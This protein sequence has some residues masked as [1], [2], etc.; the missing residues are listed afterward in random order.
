MWGSGI[1]IDTWSRSRITRFES[2]LSALTVSAAAG[3]ANSDDGLEPLPA[4]PPAGAR[5]QSRLH[6]A[7]QARERSEKSESFGSSSNPLS[8]APPAADGPVGGTS[9]ANGRKDAEPI[10]TFLIAPRTD[11]PDH[12]V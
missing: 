7:R 9:D 8:T 5:A 6:S 4:P 12:D 2:V 10:A 1:D 11:S 3:P